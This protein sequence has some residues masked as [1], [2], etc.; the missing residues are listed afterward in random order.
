MIRPERVRRACCRRVTYRIVI[1]FSFNVFFG[2]AKGPKARVFAK[3]DAANE[4]TL[5][6]PASARNVSFVMPKPNGGATLGFLG[7]W[8]KS[9]GRRL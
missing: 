2:P 3:R 7:L 4:F 8:I 9:V 5:A 1:D 6:N